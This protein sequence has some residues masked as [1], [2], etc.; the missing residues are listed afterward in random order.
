V[1]VPQAVIEQPESI[2]AQQV[3]EETNAEVARVMLERM[4]MEAFVAQSEAEV[5][6]RDVDGGGMGRRLLK[7]PNPHVANGHMIMVNVQCPSTGREYVFGVP[8]NVRTGQEAAAWMAGL[9]PSKYRP[10]VEV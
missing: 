8:P 9:D 4:G 5:L 1:R 6:H 10:E 7:I 3:I 2:T